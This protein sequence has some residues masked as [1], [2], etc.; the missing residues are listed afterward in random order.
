MKYFTIDAENNI[1]AHANRQ[2][3]RD[4]GA[5]VF[6]TEVQVADLIGPNNQRLIEI[7]NSLP[8]VKPVTKFANRKVATER[9]W[10]AIQSLGGPVA[11][12]PEK[13]SAAEIAAVEPV[14]QPPR[15]EPAPESVAPPAA[16][17][18]SI[19]AA[20]QQPD[21]EPAAASQT[22][23]PSVAPVEAAQH[24]TPFDEPVATPGV[25]AAQVAPVE[26]KTTKKASR[27]KKA[28]KGGRKAKSAEKPKSDRS[29]K[30]AEVIAMMKRAKGA[31]LPE[32]MEATGWLAHTTRAFVSILGSKGGEKIE[33]SKNAAGERTYRIAK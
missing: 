33:S 27:A 10:K 19:P 21:S 7:W 5:G 16:S 23:E 3:A 4:T 12:A 11:A 31:T 14:A 8:G 28:S 6:S 9:I 32:I 1:T 13:Q 18:P 30:K 2:A 26:A 20:D 29:N 15:P 22:Q 25:Q 17:E 24:T